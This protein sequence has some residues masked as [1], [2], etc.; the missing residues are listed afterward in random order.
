MTTQT[1]PSKTDAADA[2]CES[3]QVGAAKFQHASQHFVAEP[4]KD[5]L[6]I[7]KDYANEKPD[8]AAVWCFG[9][10]VL[11]GWKLRG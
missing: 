4:A 9:L 8:V 2:A 1:S 7:F 11:I 3:S 10:G 5:L 6:T